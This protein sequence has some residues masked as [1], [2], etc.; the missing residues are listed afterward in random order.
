M[1]LSQGPGPI[2]LWQFLLELLTDP[3]CQHFIC[4]TG[5]GW[6]FKLT[7]PDEVNLH[8]S[9]HIS[10]PVETDIFWNYRLWKSNLKKN[11]ER[12]FVTVFKCFNNVIVFQIFKRN[13]KLII[14]KLSFS[15][16]YFI[17]TYIIK[18]QTNIK[19]IYLASSFFH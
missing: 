4:W 11:G 12:F 9:I 19:F 3:G 14:Q 8:N 1:Q 16:M 10:W 13:M 15:F 7:D 17:F 2:Q 6:E 18:R 5:E